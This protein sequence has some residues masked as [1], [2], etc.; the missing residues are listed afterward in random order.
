MEGAT[1]CDMHKR[2][3]Y[4]LCCTVWFFIDSFVRGWRIYYSKE[5]TVS[6]LQVRLNIHQWL[7]W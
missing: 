6:H 3:W 5:P 7:D 1:Q 4:L 2:V